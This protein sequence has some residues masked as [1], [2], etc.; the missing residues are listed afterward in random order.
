MR[1][2]LRAVRGEM[3]REEADRGMG[4]DSSGRRY[5]IRQRTSI[6]V[7]PTTAQS[8]PPLVY[9]LPINYAHYTPKN[10]FLC[11]V[12]D[13]GLTWSR[14]CGGTSRKSSRRTPDPTSAYRCSSWAKAGI[15]DASTSNIAVALFQS[16]YQRAIS[17]ALPVNSKTTPRKVCVAR[18]HPTWHLRRVA[19]PKRRSEGCLAA[20]SCQCCI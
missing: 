10:G 13:E 15:V 16:V 9:R 6:P 12:S 7:S 8:N 4:S 17:S 1:S 19:G 11:L 20:V 5:H 3:R 2:W 18:S 14:R